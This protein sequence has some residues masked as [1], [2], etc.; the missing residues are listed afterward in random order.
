[1]ASPAF[2]EIPQSLGATIQNVHGVKGREWIDALP[3]LIRHCREIWSL[4]LDRPF[5]TLS[6][7]LVIPGR[8]FGNQE[9]VLKLGVPC[10]ELSSEAAALAHF[11]GA[12]S[13]RL[14]GD[15]SALGAL[16][17]ERVRPGSTLREIEDDAEA[18]GIAAQVMKS[19][20]RPV[21]KHLHFSSTD[22]WFLAFSRLREAHHG[23]TGPIPAALVSHAEQVFY[24]L[25]TEQSELVV[26]HA[27]LHHDNILLSSTPS[28]ISIDPKGIVGERGY[29]VGAF[30][31]NKLPLQGPEGL[32]IQTIQNR[33]S[34][35]SH[36]LG[37]DA[38]RL[39]KWAFYQTVL[40]ALW[41]NEDRT[42]YSG[43]VALAGMM[44]KML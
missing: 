1:M 23:G 6:Y 28:W 4:T 5:E 16:L 24:E 29:E 37:I 11:R 25:K 22:D 27:D 32:V 31:R 39:R 15:E 20:W 8:T 26:L 40:S 43:A 12:G 19:L 18:A 7:N 44:E 34:I 41:A 9:I 3:S 36:A 13:V 17:L 2:L 30:L 21:P 35:F 14:L 38:H 42:E 33:I 10:R